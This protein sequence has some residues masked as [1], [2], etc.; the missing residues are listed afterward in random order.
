MRI[1]IIEDEVDM[2]NALSRGLGTQGY[3]VDIASTGLEGLGLGFVHNYDLAILDLN[4][5]EMDGLEVCQQLR[6]EKPNL[7]ILILT[8]RE[9]LE[10][11][12]LGLDLGA[13]DYL[14]KP[15]HFD[16]LTARIRAILRR[17]LDGRRPTLEVGDLKL[18]PRSRTVWQGGKELSLTKKE[19][20]IL[21]HLMRRPGK[22]IS[23]EELIEHVWNEQVNIFSQSI[24]V[25]IHSL[26]VKLGDSVEN[27]Q[28]LETMIGQGYRLI[29]KRTNRGQ[30]TTE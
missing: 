17:D 8:A 25:H 19:F 29:E 4:L 18:D 21:Q 14:V 12:V 30:K 28:Y 9:R 27:P 1:L 5:P 16:E 22:V 23:Q 3:A 15:F 6:S 26:R 10:D 7:P 24:R 20:G 11:R 2:A 13:D